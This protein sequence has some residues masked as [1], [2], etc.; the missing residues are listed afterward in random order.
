MTLN[1]ALLFRVFLDSRLRTL[2]YPEAPGETVCLQRG[3]H[4]QSGW[5]PFLSCD[6]FAPCPVPLPN[7]LLWNVQK[8]FFFF[9]A[10]HKYTQQT[11][12]TLLWAGPGVASAVTL[13][14]AGGSRSQDAD[15]W[16]SQ[17]P[18]RDERR[19][20][21][22]EAAD[23]RAAASPAAGTSR[24]SPGSLSLHPGAPTGPRPHHP[25]SSGRAARSGGTR[26]GPAAK[27]R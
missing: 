11:Q 6:S 26:P 14:L 15:S 24:A 22:A 4:L 1:P 10:M 2:N 9:K 16:S 12:Q 25:Q 7:P 21:G 13:G 23:V 17:L 3:Q 8:T 19:G 20:A 5:G 27:G 18:G